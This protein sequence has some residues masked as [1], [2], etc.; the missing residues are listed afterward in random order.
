MEQELEKLRRQI[1]QLTGEEFNLNSPKQLGQVLFEKMGLPTP[2]RRGKGKV[3]STAVDV[4]GELAPEHVV[5]RLVLEYRQLAKVKSTYVDAL[6][7]LVNP[8]TGRLHT[9]YN[10]ARGAP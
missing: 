7:Q 8:R 9:S 4:L 10:Q 3:F 5:P 6:P 1:Y 2:R